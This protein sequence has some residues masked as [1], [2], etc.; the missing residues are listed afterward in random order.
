MNH[1]IVMRSTGSW[2]Q[3]LMPGGKTIDCRLKGKLKISG[4]KKTNFVSVGDHV[5][6]EEDG[7]GGGVIDEVLPRKNYIIRKATN[8][9]RQWHV[10]AANLD[11]AVLVATLAEPRT[12]TG[13]ID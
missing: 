4:S 6:V 12:S 7:S 13:F 11:Q 9:S 10:L 8:L 3:V 1:G 2:Y 5:N